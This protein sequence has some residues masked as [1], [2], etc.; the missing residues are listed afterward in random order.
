MSNMNRKP[1]RTNEIVHLSMKPLKNGCKR[2]FLDFS[3]EGKRYKEY[4]TNLTVKP[5][6][7]TENRAYNKEAK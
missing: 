5:A 1:K 2:Y 6:N 7:S 4:L 3:F